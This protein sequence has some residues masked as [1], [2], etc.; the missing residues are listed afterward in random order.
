MG[1]L[2]AGDEDTW[3]PSPEREKGHTHRGTGAGAGGAHGADHVGL[4]LRVGLD[5][6]VDAFVV[7][8]VRQHGH[9]RLPPHTCRVQRQGSTDG[10]TRGGVRTWRPFCASQSATRVWAETGALGIER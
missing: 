5:Q 3:Q 10:R 9:A 6:H 7:A 4:L 1:F 8:E 2:T